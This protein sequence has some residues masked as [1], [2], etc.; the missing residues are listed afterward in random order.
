MLCDPAER[1]DPCGIGDKW[2]QYDNVSSNIEPVVFFR[3]RRCS[4]YSIVE[5]NKNL[6]EKEK[7][8]ES[9]QYERGIQ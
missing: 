5:D 4:L 1:N 6:K 8:D 2:N 7:Q 9:D 3:F